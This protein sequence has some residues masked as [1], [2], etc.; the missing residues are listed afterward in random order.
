MHLQV[1]NF[2]PD[3][4][5]LTFSATGL[6]GSINALG[7]TATVLTSGSVMDENSFANPNKVSHRSLLAFRSNAS[8]SVEPVALGYDMI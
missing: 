1:V 7:S 6:Q 4:V 8:Q 5:S 2:G 3:A